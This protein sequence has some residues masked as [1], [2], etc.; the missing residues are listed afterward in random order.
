MPM[1]SGAREEGGGECV[2]CHKDKLRFC[3]ANDMEPW[4]NE[5]GVP[6]IRPD[7]EDRSNR[8]WLHPSE[9]LA[10][11]A[12]LEPMTD[13]EE[14]LIALAHAHI[15]VHRTTGGGVAYRGHVVLFPQQVSPALTRDGYP[16][17]SPPSA[18]VDHP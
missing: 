16:R 8:E 7:R 9:P 1:H 14:C 6:V 12:G 13:A 5:R 18:V 4:I 2:Q 15:Q 3:A 10:S 17:A 11:V